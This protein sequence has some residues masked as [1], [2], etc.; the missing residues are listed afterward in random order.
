MA[1]PGLSHRARMSFVR[2]LARAVRYGLLS[3]FAAAW[4]VAAHAQQADPL[5]SWNEGASK[6]RILAFVQAVTDKSG[7]EFVPPGERVATFDNDGTLWA[8]QPL[9]FQFR[10]MLDQLEA[11]APKHPE[12]KDDPAFTALAAHDQQALAKLGMKPVLRLLAVANSGMNVGDYDKTIRDWLATARH[13]KF[14]R[15]YTDLVYKPMQELL[16]YLR[17]NG[18][19]TFIVSG[20]SI[21]FMR[22]WVEKAYGIPPE[23]VIGTI[24]DVTFQMKDGAPVLVRNPKIAFVDDGPGKPV[25][26]YRSIGRRPIAAFGNSDG[27]LQMLQFTA[28]GPGS[29]LMLIVHHDDAGREFAYDRKSRVGKLDKAWDEATAKGWTVV[30]MRNDWKTIFNF[31]K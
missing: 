28:A 11:A 19:K 15:P 8:E 4:L 27:D 26:I 24:S 13:P 22:P 10:F 12:W 7:K 18:F 1:L 23:Q 16:A 29:R 25:G 21:E 2:A 31:E 6:A 5:P 9:Y 17:A 20:G 14:K 3:L 30:S